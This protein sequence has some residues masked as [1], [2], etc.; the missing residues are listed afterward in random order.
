M[1]PETLAR[2]NDLGRRLLVPVGVRVKE[3]DASD[4]LSDKVPHRNGAG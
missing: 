2:G 3:L 1:H 4:E